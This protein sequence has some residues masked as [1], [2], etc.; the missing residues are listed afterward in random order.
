MSILRDL[1]GPGTWGTAGNLVAWVICGALGAGGAYLLRHRIGRGLAGWWN[2]HH[3]QHA[4]EQ[5][6]EA[7]R[8]HEEEKRQREDG[9]P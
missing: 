6:L 7:L 4:I 2:R 3:R 8:R 5:H 9:V 1:F